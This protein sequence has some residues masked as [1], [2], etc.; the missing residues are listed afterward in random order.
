[1]LLH[2]AY[3]YLGLLAIGVWQVWLFVVWHGWPFTHIR[4]QGPRVVLANTVVI[5]GGALTY[6]VL[7]DLG[8]LPPP[9]INAAAGSFIAAGLSMSMLFEGTLPNRVPR[10]AAVLLLAAA[11]YLG[12][13]AYA[14][15]I[16]WTHSSPTEWVA[17]VTLNGI[18]A[19]IILHV[20]IGR[21]WPFGNSN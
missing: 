20:A 10:L 6:T 21:R 7:H 19:G 1:V 11:L 14:N 15:S 18:A 16:H 4:R 9:T 8:G 3:P 13:T 17:H 5:G 2:F 12:L